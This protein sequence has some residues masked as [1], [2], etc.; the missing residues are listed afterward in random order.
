MMRTKPAVAAGRLAVLLSGLLLAGLSL[1]IRA[2]DPA[3]R[4]YPARIVYSRGAE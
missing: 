3:P 1:P 2:A 4:G